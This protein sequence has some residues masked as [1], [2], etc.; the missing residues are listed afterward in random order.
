MTSVTSLLVMSFRPSSD[1]VLVLQPNGPWL[2]QRPRL[3]D[4]VAARLRARRLDHALAAGTPPEANAALALRA[5]R[6]TEPGRRCVIA[7]SLRRIARDG[8]PHG[9]AGVLPSGAPV[10]VAA[11]PLDRLAETLDHPGPVSAEGV[12]QAWLL[13]TDGMGPLYNAHAAV[14]LRASAARATRALHPPVAC[15]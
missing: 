14:S 3:R 5:R 2:A 9:P 6:L 12:A 7:S 1:T 11:G 8:S 10:A 15:C 13:L 4:R